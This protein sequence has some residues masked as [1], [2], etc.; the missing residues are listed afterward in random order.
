MMRSRA[1]RNREERAA[2]CEAATRPGEEDRSSETEPGRES[3]Y[4]RGPHP[5]GEYRSSETEPGRESR[6]LRGPHPGG[7]Y[8]SS[9][10]EPGRESRHPRGRFP[11]EEDRSSET[12]STTGLHT[13]ME[14][15]T[16]T[17]PGQ[18]ILIVLPIIQILY[19]QFISLLFNLMSPIIQ[20]QFHIIHC[21]F[22][23]L[24][25]YNK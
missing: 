23:G 2:T 21:R 13:R 17:R 19:S 11:G 25:W 16:G 22:I 15:S 24:V 14:S 12:D 1:R 7:E 20:I 8:R 3:R 6:Y 18:N 4:P 10:T 5:G 9:E